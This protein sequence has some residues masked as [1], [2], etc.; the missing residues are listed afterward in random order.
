MGGLA[1]S[2]FVALAL[3]VMITAVVAPLFE[4]ASLRKE[5]KA[6]SA[7]LAEMIADPLWDLDLN[8]AEMLG[9]AFASDM[10]VVRVTI[11]ETESRETRTIERSSTTDT[12]LVSQPVIYQGHLVGT[13]GLAFDR[14]I[15]RAQIVRD[16]SVATLV[17]L[18]VLVASFTGMRW[19]LGKLRESELARSAAEDALEQ[20]NAALAQA[21]KM[22]S[23]GRLAGGVAHD[24]NNMLGVIMGHVEFALRQ[25][26]RGNP[27]REDLQEILKATTR[28]ADL[29]RQLLA[30]ARK[31]DVVPRVLDVNAV[32]SDSLNMLERLIGEDIELTWTPAADLW[33]ISMDPS[34]LDQIIANLCVNAR[35]AIPDVGSLAI[36][37]T[38]CTV[39]EKFA[40]SHAD[41][42]RGDY[43]R[44]TVRDNGR[45]MTEEIA[46]HIFEPFY[47]TKDVGEGTGLGLATVH[48]A[49]LQNGGFVTV[50]S[51]V[52]RG[53]TFELYIPRETAAGAAST[54]EQASAAAAGAGGRE[55]IL[56]V[57]DEPM[58]L[59][60]AARGLEMQGYAILR[61]KS[62]AEAVQL[63]GE[64][65]GAIDLLLTDIVM[66]MMNGRD[67]ALT[68]MKRRPSIKVIF[69]SG[70][71]SDV[72]R[73]SFESLGESHFIG[74][75][76]T[77]AALSEK[78]RSV[79]DEATTASTKPERA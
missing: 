1:T 20:T 35:D 38:N 2:I 49:V 59:R 73:D 54:E 42:S 21:Q 6:A 9:K 37:T 51:V 50:D 61:A 19:Q 13:I 74:K 48:G 32:V 43:V 23:I 27:L 76:F 40:A 4:E 29:T 5:T 7:R 16:V 24:F 79:L 75:P 34:Q 56:I 53:T 69:M 30:F 17:A 39:D 64:R 70:Y 22:D 60:M 11:L 52:G 26:P 58:L 31:Q 25:T 47:T 33:P 71:T 68:I 18:L 77:L 66:P 28:S 67:L 55:T 63:A 12:I 62:P 10:R 78:V 57:E 36:A 8:R 41:A 44:I 72:G 3:A 45:G 65:E 14:G 15:Y 46:S